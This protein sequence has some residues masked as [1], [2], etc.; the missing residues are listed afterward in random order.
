[1][2]NIDTAK[3]FMDP[4]HGYIYIP[5]CFVEN[6]IDTEYF[7][8]LRNIEQT[9]M[10][11]L[12]PDSKHDRFGHSLGVF[13]LGS[14]AVDALLENFSHD[15]YWYIRSDHTNILFW[16][17][18]KVLFLIAC[19]LHDIGHVPFSHALEKEIY[20]NSGNKE[21]EDRLIK[22][23][24][25]KEAQQGGV[26]D[27]I[28]QIDAAEHERLGAMLVLE[29]LSENIRNIFLTLEEMSYPVLTTD[30]I[31]YAEHYHYNPT[32][33]TSEF[34]SDLCFIARMIMGLKY[35]EFT[36]EK[37]IKNC[38][39][40]LLNGSNFDVDKLDYIVRDTKMSGISN[41]AIDIDRLLNSVSIIPATL[42]ERI[43][44]NDDTRF[45]KKTIHSLDNFNTNN[46]VRICGAFK[47]SLIIQPHAKVNI[48]PG[49][50]FISM[51]GTEG[52]AYI[53]HLHD[54]VKFDLNTEI[55]QNGQYIGKHSGG[56]YK[57]LSDPPNNSAFNCN[58]KNATLLANENFF[59]EV[60]ENCTIEIT[61]NG[62]CD[63]E[64]EGAF[65]TKSSIILFENTKITGTAKKITVLG[66]LITAE[67][68]SK[69]NYNTF[70]I[71]FK[72]QATNIIANVLEARDYLYLWCYA[73]HKVIYYA[74][75]LIPA[76]AE[77][78]FSSKPPES[79][80]PLWN[81][82]YDNLMYLDDSYIW[83]VVR[84]LRNNTSTALKKLCNELLCRKYKISL[85]KSLAEYDLIF[86]SFEG[87]QKLTIRNFFAQ[88]IQTNLPN[89]KGEEPDTYIAGFIDM[90]F[91]QILMK[92]H[93]ALSKLTNIVFVD[94]SYK[95]KITDT[96]NTF[97][98]MNNEVAPMDKIPLLTDNIKIS[99]TTTHYFYL[100]YD[101]NTSSKLSLSEHELLKNTIVKIFEENINSL[102]MEELISKYDI[103]KKLPAQT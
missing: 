86:K 73:H 75:F 84:F 99:Q 42:Y 29:K 74:N 101:L 88:N 22:L 17:K 48:S 100:F 103:N 51:Q 78:I 18:N 65:K 59:F 14:K 58:I 33:D 20:R 2:F 26:H 35:T 31:L 36:P 43:T 41:I 70:S 23:I 4:I 82:N 6:L 25:E 94:A 16:A 54:R 96:H 60:A 97:I 32:I 91:L 34:D 45:S 21:F 55:Y 15:K 87:K 50:T 52:D 13:H 12:Y 62:K 76:I 8:R 64:I 98:M 30:S 40:E 61:I 71:G 93:E 66:N 1:M 69:D 53:K 27:T 79:T 95:Q 38:F 9:G 90:K 47:S 92:E 46:T 80:F 77:N 56:S 37:Q 10:R 68:P 83:T 19:L 28:T 63:I 57:V 85:W 49:S 102:S 67:A 39:I 7:Q 81:L 72:K 44:F 89:V 5:R 24:N 11:V 3:A